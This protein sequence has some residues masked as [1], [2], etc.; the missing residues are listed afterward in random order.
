MP[1]RFGLLLCILLLLSCDSFR[2][3]FK[4]RLISQTCPLNVIVP[5]GDSA[6]DFRPIPY[7]E[8]HSNQ[9]RGKKKVTPTSATALVEDSDWFDNSTLFLKSSKF[10]VKVSSSE[11]EIE[12]IYETI[13]DDIEDISVDTAGLR[14]LKSFAISIFSFFVIF[15]S[16]FSISYLLFP[17][18][19][20]MTYS[21]AGCQDAYCSYMSEPEYSES[22]GVVFHESDLPQAK[23]VVNI[24]P[25]VSDKNSIF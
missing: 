23:R 3:H 15:V 16:V 2:L 8:D 24:S 6:S 25:R 1:D 12:E 5:F 11:E 14:T 7:D 18:S 4:K 13:R 10:I 22:G 21:V 19:F 17:G 9:S 20:R